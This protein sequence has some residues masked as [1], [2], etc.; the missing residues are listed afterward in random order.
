MTTV[1]PF[2]SFQLEEKNVN[3]IFCVLSDKFQKLKTLYF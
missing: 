2:Y 1:N 3:I